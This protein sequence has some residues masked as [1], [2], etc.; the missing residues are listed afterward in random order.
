MIVSL[1]GGAPLL[2]FWLGVSNTFVG[3]LVWLHWQLTGDS[4]VLNAFFRYPNTILT[5]LVCGLE[6]TWCWDA[7]RQFKPGDALRSGWFWLTAAA[8][9]H[10]MGRALAMPG[11][12]RFYIG[13]L[14]TVR[15]VGTAIG[16]P[17]QM[18][19]LL[20]GLS[21]FAKYSSDIGLF[22]RMTKT[23]YA[24]LAIVAGFGIRT[25]YGISAYLNAGKAVT[26]TRVVSWLSDPL[27]LLLLVVAVLLRRSV[28][29]LGAGMI[30][31]CWRSFIVAIVLT[32]A[33]S[34][35]SWCL[36][37][38]V[39]PVWTSI[40]WFVWFAADAAFAM[41][42][43]LQVAAVDRLKSRSYLLAAEPRR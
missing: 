4:P 11:Y 42:P 19:L 39:T 20:C 41:G 13:A 23:D 3:F 43:A 6:L 17:L 29:P 10:L 22:R 35:S 28:A 37:C 8:V 5:L 33:A 18:V 30:A 24:L 38:T 25:V 36:D 15:D 34:A 16:G 7:A 40:G 9:A 14:V 32:S 1:R 12:D 21:Q 2:I 27:L 26:W 31:N